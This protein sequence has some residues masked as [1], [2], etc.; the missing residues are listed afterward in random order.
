MTLCFAPPKEAGVVLKRA[1][2]RKEKT[3]PKF[4]PFPPSCS[5]FYSLVPFIFTWGL[6]QL[7]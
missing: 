3:L 7:P 2:R 5:L 1:F 4:I 6:L